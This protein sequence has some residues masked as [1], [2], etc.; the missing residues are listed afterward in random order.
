GRIGRFMSVDRV[1][2]LR[3]RE[4]GHLFA[5]EHA[6]AAPG[7]PSLPLAIVSDDLPWTIAALLHER[8]IA[9]SSPDDLPDDA[10]AD[11]RALRQ[12]GILSVLALPLVSGGR[13]FGALV[14]ETMAAER[15]WPAELVARQQLIAEVFAS[16]L[17]RKE[18]EDAVRASELMKSAILSSLN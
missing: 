17:A 18:N 16:A 7:V 8:P 4:A 13:T 3:M 15:A 9:I 5:V 1:L 14:L 10:D 6:W 11:R 2:L 12:Y